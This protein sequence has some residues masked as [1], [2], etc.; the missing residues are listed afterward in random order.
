MGS[1]SSFKSK[2]AHP[3][4][5]STPQTEHRGGWL[6]KKKGRK[7]TNGNGVGVARRV[8]VHPCGEA[9]R[10]SWG[11]NAPHRLGFERDREPWKKGSGVD[12][13]RD[14]DIK[15]ALTFRTPHDENQRNANSR[16]ARDGVGTMQTPRSV[17]PGAQ[18]ERETE[19][20]K[21]N[22]KSRMHE[23]L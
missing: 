2:S 18:R 16:E 8:C 14:D 22:K 12:G 19:H 23:A 17:R 5:G 10:T 11:R 6:Q 9:R 21:P 13:S 3:G 7:Q 1:S 20:K 15:R 4:E